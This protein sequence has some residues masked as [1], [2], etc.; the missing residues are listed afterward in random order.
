MRRKN[1]QRGGPDAV[2]GV[3]DVVVE[4]AGGALVVV[5]WDACDVCDVCDLCDVCDAAWFD[6]PHALHTSAMLPASATAPTV[7]LRIARRYQPGMGAAERRALARRFRGEGSNLQHPAPKA[8]VLPIEL[9][10]RRCPFNQV[11]RPAIGAKNFGRTQDLGLLR[12]RHTG[13]VVAARAATGRE[14]PLRDRLR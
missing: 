6:P 10:R 13:I 8:D 5:S 14:P 3:V 7:L 2:A 1:A 4:D 12:I 9:P 11:A